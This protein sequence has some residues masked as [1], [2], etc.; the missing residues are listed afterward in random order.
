MGMDRLREWLKTHTRNPEKKK[1]RYQRWR[2]RNLSQERIRS[3]NNA[4][5]WYGHNKERALR[6]QRNHNKA[7]W[8]EFLSHYGSACGC[9]GE[10]E[11]AFLTMDHIHN[12]GAKKKRE[13]SRGKGQFAHRSIST[14]RLILD[15]K[16]RQWPTNEVQVWCMNCNLGKRRLGYCPHAIVDTAAIS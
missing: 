15:L 3:K 7:L 11:P 16:R 6:Q 13:L 2:Q 10:T 5:V 12:D 14:Y 8:A 9:C 4:R 1:A